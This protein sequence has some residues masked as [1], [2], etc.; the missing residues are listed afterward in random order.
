MSV[1]KRVT[2]RLRKVKRKF[3][4]TLIFVVTVVMGATLIIT[5]RS[6]I[7]QRREKVKCIDNE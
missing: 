1:F 3:A 6:V 5:V 2:E 4:Y 7:N